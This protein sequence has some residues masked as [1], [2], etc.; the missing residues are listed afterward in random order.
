MGDQMPKD[1]YEYIKAIQDD[2]LECTNMTENEA[3]N[4]AFRC[5][6]L[7]YKKEEQSITQVIQT[8]IKALKEDKS[9]GSYF[10]SWQAN[11]ACAIMDTMPEKENIHALANESARRFL[12]ILIR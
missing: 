9:E 7:G 2:C 12:D 8:L 3:W 6:Q 10:Y 1:Q 11:I 4:F 5:W